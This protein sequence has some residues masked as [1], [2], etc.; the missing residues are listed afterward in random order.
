MRTSKEQ[1]VRKAAM[2][3]VLQV[4]YDQAATIW[5]HRTQSYWIHNNGVSNVNAWDDNMITWA[6]L[7]KN[8]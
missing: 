7:V 1:T 4:I 3:Q 6:D 2:A 8:S 5:L